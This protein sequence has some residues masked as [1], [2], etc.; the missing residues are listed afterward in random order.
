MALPSGPRPTIFSAR[1]VGVHEAN[2]ATD[3]SLIRFNRARHLVD[4][5]V[6]L[7]ISDTVEHE[8]RST[9]SNFD[10]AGDFV[11]T[12]AVLAVSQHPHGD[13]PFIQTDSA[14]LE[15]GPD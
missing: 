12:H 1:L 5:A 13:Q 2:L 10:S 9:L 6:V 4:A 7:R 15:D 11:G 14:V 3:E 8:P